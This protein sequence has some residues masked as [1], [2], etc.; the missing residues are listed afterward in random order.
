MTTE[1]LEKLA[2]MEC[3]TCQGVS[4][5][6]GICDCEPVGPHEHAVPCPACQENG[7]P[8]GL[9]LPELTERCPCNTGEYA[10]LGRESETVHCKQCSCNGTGGTLLQGD[11]L[12]VA[13]V[14]IAHRYGYQVTLWLNG[15]VTFWN[16]AKQIDRKAEGKGTLA[17]LTEALEGVTGANP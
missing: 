12:L 7:Q 16:H 15:D 6:D 4:V 8:T 2:R 10:C 1:R 3:R 14:T 13:G 9:A 11:S 17:A 5:I